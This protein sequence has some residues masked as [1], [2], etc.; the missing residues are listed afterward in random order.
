[1]QGLLREGDRTLIHFPPFT[2]LLHLLPPPIVLHS[3]S[4]RYTETDRQEVGVY[5]LTRALNLGT[6]LC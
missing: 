3:N 2:L 6:S 4:P 1:M 5:L